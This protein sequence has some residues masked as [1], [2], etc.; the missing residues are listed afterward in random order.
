VAVQ[1]VVNADSQN[2]MSNLIALSKLQQ[3]ITVL[4]KADIGNTLYLAFMA[5]IIS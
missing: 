1:F 3:F 2:K 4:G 5:E